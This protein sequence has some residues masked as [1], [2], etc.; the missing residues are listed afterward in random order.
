MGVR[1]ARRGIP[2]STTAKRQP[3]GGF[4]SQAALKSELLMSLRRW[5]RTLKKQHI[6][7]IGGTKLVKAPDK[8]ILS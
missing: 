4:T 6:R 3:K 7:P 5:M 2:S 8:V 1:R